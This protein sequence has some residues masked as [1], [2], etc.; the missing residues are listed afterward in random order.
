MHS[1]RRAAL[2]RRQRALLTWSTARRGSLLGVS[3]G[4]AVM[5]AGC[6]GQQIQTAEADVLVSAFATSGMDALGGGRL[7]VVGGC[8]GTDGVV[9][10]WPHRTRVVREQPL[11]IEVPDAGVVSLGEQVVLGGGFVLEHE[12][13]GPSSSPGPVE[14]GGVSVPAECASHDVFLASTG[15]AR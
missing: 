4:A 14:V 12:P 13:G 9:V 11:T 15:V 5:L 2:V 6:G 8:L 10:I 7:E 1:A 3:L